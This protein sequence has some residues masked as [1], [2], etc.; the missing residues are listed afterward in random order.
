MLTLDNGTLVKA[1]LGA[2][3]MVLMSVLG[4]LCADAWADI[5]ANK[6]QIAELNVSVANYADK[7][8]VT[9]LRETIA[10]LNETIQQLPN[11]FPPLAYE[12]RIEA[13][14]LELIRKIDENALIAREDMKE[15]RDTIMGLHGFGHLSTTGGP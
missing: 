6:D 1:V 14:F 5:K 8:H 9:K 3:S 11:E 12:S 2:L 13:R 15:L 10:V 4:F 7:E